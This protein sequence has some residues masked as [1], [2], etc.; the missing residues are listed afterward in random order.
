M[1]TDQLQIGSSL[2]AL[3]LFE[4]LATLEE[5]STKSSTPLIDSAIFISLPASPTPKEWAKVRRV[6]GRRVVNAYCTSDLVLAGIGRLHEVIGGGRTTS[7]A[8]L[9]AVN[10]SQLGIEDIDVT[11][12][13]DGKL[14]CFV[15]EP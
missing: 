7:L 10:E 9:A 3:V 4:A 1:K 15:Q 11:E 2:G 14:P 5:S 6:V 8:G 13:V 12:V